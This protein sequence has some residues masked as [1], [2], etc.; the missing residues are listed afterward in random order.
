LILIKDGI[1]YIRSDA[2]LKIA[3]ELDGFWKILLVGKIVPKP[4]RE[5]MYSKTAK[6]LT[7]EGIPNIFMGQDVA[8]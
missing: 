4:F 1:A 2:V 8:S 5:W 7:T 3:E 6:I